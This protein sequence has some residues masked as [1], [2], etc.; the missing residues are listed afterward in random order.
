MARLLLCVQFLKVPI[1]STQIKQRNVQELPHLF[2]EAVTSHITVSFCY[3]QGELPGKQHRSNR[4]EASAVWKDQHLHRR[5]DDST[6]LK[7]VHQ[8]QRLCWFTK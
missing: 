4:C 6:G 7:R 1:L 8:C 3:G 5:E 2:P